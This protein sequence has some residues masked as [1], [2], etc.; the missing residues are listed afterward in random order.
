MRCSASRIVCQEP[1]VGE[2]EIR[3]PSLPVRS[4][5]PRRRSARLAQMAPQ[6]YVEEHY[7]DA[8]ERFDDNDEY[9][10]DLDDNT[11]SESPVHS[12][13]SQHVSPTAARGRLPPSP[14]RSRLLRRAVATTTTTAASRPQTDANVPKQRTV[15][16]PPFFHVLTA[17]MQQKK[18]W[19]VATWS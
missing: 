13:D 14:T 2:S 5:V 16:I 17:M 1:A 15:S 10:P 19:N 8:R 12:P 6:L 9:N 11:T 3:V 4:K 7:D 18:I